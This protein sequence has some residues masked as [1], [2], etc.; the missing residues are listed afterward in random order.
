MDSEQHK[1]Q[2]YHH[3]Y[4]TFATISEFV[5]AFSLHILATFKITA[6]AMLLGSVT[7]LLYTAVTVCYL[8]YSLQTI[9]NI[10]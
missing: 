5:I 8:R 2:K 1:Q 9:K 10:S 7:F 4:T 6:V 3:Y